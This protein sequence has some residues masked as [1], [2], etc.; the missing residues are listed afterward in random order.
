M[1]QHADSICALVVDD[2]EQARRRVT[3]LLAKDCD[4]GPCLEAENGEDAVLLIQEAKPDI[5][6]LD[7]QMPGVDGFGVIEAIGAENMPLTV[8]V[9][10][11]DR[12]ALRAFEA[13]A[14]DYLLKPFG[15]R[16]YQRTL[17][18]VKDR[19]RDLRSR[20]S[21][22][23]GSFGSESLKLAAS[24]SRPGAIWNW[25]AVKRG[26][27]TRLV[28]TEDIDWIEVAGVY[29]AVH[30]LG[31]EFLYRDSLAAVATRLD[32]CRFVRIH[33]STI[34]NLNSITL[35]ERRS[36]GEFDVTLKDG[37]QLVM[38]RTY[39]RQFEAVLGHQL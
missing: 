35:L 33:R 3:T 23:S 1:K 10:A 36:H 9:T 28:M 31:Q 5:V 13:D 24:R 6:F 30:A 37:A 16:R 15:N 29:V 20:G 4:I 38:S 12:F 18:R 11:Y 39:R 14:V 34:V 19:V 2:E 7:V 17:E 27:T 8:F 32:P 21:A 25:I 26:D 22:D